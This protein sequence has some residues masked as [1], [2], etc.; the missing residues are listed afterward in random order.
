MKKLLALFTLLLVSCVSFSFANSEL[1][2]AV[3][4]MYD[5]GLTKFD[6][7]TEFMADKPLRRDEATKFF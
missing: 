7:A 4:W 5:N 2:T 3:Q 1:D 6:N